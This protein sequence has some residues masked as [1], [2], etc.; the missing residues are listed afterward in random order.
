[1][2]KGV[3]LAAGV[4]DVEPAVPW[5]GV[6]PEGVAGPLGIGA[7]FSPS[8]MPVQEMVNR[9]QMGTRY[10]IRDLASHGHTDS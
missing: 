5:F 2:P 10:F 7:C 4:D 1:M 3:V 8:R 9:A 6:S